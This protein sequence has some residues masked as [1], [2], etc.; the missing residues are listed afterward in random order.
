MLDQFNEA[1]SFPGGRTNTTMKK[2]QRATIPAFDSDIDL[3]PLLEL[4][5]ELAEVQKILRFTDGLIDQIVYQL[6]GLTDEEISTIEGS[7]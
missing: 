3:T 1:K 7:A 2:L 4:E 5:A 6:Y